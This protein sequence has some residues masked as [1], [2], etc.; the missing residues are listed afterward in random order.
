MGEGMK[1]LI[2]RKRRFFERYKSEKVISDDIEIEIVYIF[3]VGKKIRSRAE[4]FDRV[5]S[6][7][8]KEFFVKSNLLFLLADSA[9]D[10]IASRHGGVDRD[11]LEV[12]V[13][14]LNKEIIEKLISF[15]LNV[16]RVLIHSDIKPENFDFLCSEAGVCPEFVQG[17][18]KQ[19]V[20]VVFGE[21]FL[22]KHLPTGKTYYDIL[23]V[24]P[25]ESD[26]YFMPE[27]N[28]IFSEYL[29]QNPEKTKHVKI[30]DLMSK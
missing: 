20:V 14:F 24:I 18:C 8:F 3:R 4:Q 30:S 23:P 25:R 10:K 19:N 2:L 17:D 16:R 22:I 11:I 6:L 7:D 26:A 21:E 27:M 28:I 29:R 5:L 13:D 12:Q 9:C 15:A 1:F